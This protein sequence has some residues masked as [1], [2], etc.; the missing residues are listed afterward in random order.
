MSPISPFLPLSWNHVLTF[1]PSSQSV[2]HESGAQAILLA[3][4]RAL[5]LLPHTHLPPNLV[6]PIIPT[7]PSTSALQTQLQ[8]PKSSPNMPTVSGPATPLASRPTSPSPSR[9]NSLLPSLNVPVFR[10]AWLALAGISTRFDAEAFIPHA[11]AVLNLP[12]DRIKV[13]NGE[14]GAEL[15]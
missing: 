11:M 3:T 12:A 2:G 10:Y 14:F 8:V 1:E 15:T 5:S 6:I 9:R 7:P 4:Y 13:T